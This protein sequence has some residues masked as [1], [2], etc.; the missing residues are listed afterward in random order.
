MKDETNVP[1]KNGC[2]WYEW[3]AAGETSCN[4]DSITYFNYIVDN[5]ILDAESNSCGIISIPSIKSTLDNDHIHILN[6][7]LK[8]YIWILDIKF[9]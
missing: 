9:N 4:N 1:I 3:F 8:W 7:L 6:Y 5:S 2:R